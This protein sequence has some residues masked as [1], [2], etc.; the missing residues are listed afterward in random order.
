M[1]GPERRQSILELLADRGEVLIAEVCKRTG[2][3]QMTIRRDLAA[4]EREG[5]LQRVHG[6]AVARQSRSYEP[7][8]ALRALRHQDAKARIAAAAAALVAE[9]ETVAVDVGTTAI[10]LARALRDRSNITVVTPNLRA[11]LEVATNPDIRVIVTGGTVRPG[12]LSMVG[13]MSERV[14]AELR[15]DIVFLGVGAID[16][17][18]GVTEF[19]LDDALVKRAACRHAR[20]RVALADTS[21]LGRVAFAQVCAASDVDVLITDSEADEHLLAP[22][23]DLGMEVLVA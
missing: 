21:K 17:E 3:S 15:C 20:R 9:G 5:A 7:P 2:V 11:A 6:G 23:R 8:F 10:E 14:F 4:L 13:Q 22:L 12:E 18:A 19:N 1:R 16:A